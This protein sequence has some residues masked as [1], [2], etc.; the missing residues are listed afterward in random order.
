MDFESPAQLFATTLYDRYQPRSLSFVFLP[1]R[2]LTNG[3]VPQLDQ[4]SSILRPNFPPPKEIPPHKLALALA[5]L[6]SGATVYEVD[7]LVDGGPISVDSNALG[8][9]E[10]VVFSEVLPFEESPIKGKA[11]LAIA[12][13][14]GAKVG[15]IAAGATHPALLLITVPVGILVCTAAAII[16]PTL[17][18]FISGLVGMTPTS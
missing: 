6:L 15:M 17:G 4:L 2:S 11:P 12:A 5:F 1:K 16:G 10:Y 13:S 18:G 3:I 7:R 14:A 8:F 9:A